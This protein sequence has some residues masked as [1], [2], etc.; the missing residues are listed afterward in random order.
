MTRKKGKVR[1]GTINIT[2]GYGE[3]A[4]NLH[5]VAKDC[6][7]MHLDVILVTETRIG[8]KR[9]ARHSGEY[10]IAASETAKN[11]GGVA[12]FISERRAD[13]CQLD[14]WI[15]DMEVYDTNVIACTLVTGTMQ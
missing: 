5:T 11:R 3:A 9:Y 13:E 12:S 6:N 2:A 15:E 8:S 10:T 14:W 7:A 4:E 1:I